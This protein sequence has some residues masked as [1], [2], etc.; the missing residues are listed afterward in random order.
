MLHQEKLEDFVLATGITTI[1]REFVKMTFA[2]L[3][4]KLGLKG[5]DDN[6]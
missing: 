4:I 6:E 2:K 1:I 5:I 3:G